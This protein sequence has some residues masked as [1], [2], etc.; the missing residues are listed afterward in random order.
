MIKTHE[1]KDE[2]CGTVIQITIRN[3]DDILVT[4]HSTLLELLLVITSFDQFSSK[5]ICSPNL[6]ILYEQKRLSKVMQRKSLYYHLLMITASR[7]T[8]Y[9]MSTKKTSIQ[10]G[11]LLVLVELELKQ[12][13]FQLSQNKTI[14]RQEKGVQ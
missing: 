10:T 14:S 1:I 2:L 9:M 5:V 6:Q 13:T 11:N 7:I 12:V 8:M 4:S 3:N